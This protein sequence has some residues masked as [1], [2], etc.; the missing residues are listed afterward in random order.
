M[1]DVFVPAG[2]AAGLEGDDA[3]A[4]AED[5]VLVVNRLT[6]EDV[7]R[8]RG[9]DARADAFL[10]EQFGRSHR[11]HYLGTGGDE[12]EVAVGVAVE[13]VGAAPDIMRIEGGA[14]RDDVDL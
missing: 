5:F 2:G 8:R 10:A 14:V 12:G 9:D 13:D 7:E 1:V 6:I 11:Q 4:I 3:A